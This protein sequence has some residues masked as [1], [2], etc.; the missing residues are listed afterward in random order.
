MDSALPYGVSFHAPV[1]LHRVSLSFLLP[2]TLQSLWLPSDISVHDLLSTMSSCTLKDVPLNKTAI[3][4]EMSC[5][6]EGF[7]PPLFSL[8]H[9]SF[10]NILWLRANYFL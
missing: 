10:L 7:P 6:F 5:I 9:K 2:R 8:C 1:D 4:S 3:Y